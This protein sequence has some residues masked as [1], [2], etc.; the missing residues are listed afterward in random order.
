MS[1]AKI[2]ALYFNGLGTGKTRKREKLAMRYLA[3]RSI[4]VEHVHI[5]WRSGEYFDALLQ[6]SIDRTKAALKQHGKVLLV[7]SSAGGSL[8]VNILSQLHN[9]NLY[10]VTLCSRLHPAKLPWWDRRTLKKMAYI[11]TTKASQAFYDSVTYCGEQ[12]IPQLTITDKA[13]LLIVCQW[14]DDVVPR[15]SM[16]IPGVQTYTVPAI[17]HGWGIAAGVRQLPRI[18]RLLGLK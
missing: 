18:V 13:R 9:Q 8:V 1:S 2:H 17:G 16:N 15:A 11:G 6:R 10:G 7:G 14:A 4:L 5:D 3:K 12:A